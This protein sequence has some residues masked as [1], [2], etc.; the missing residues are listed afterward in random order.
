LERVQQP[1]P[2][3]ALGGEPA[4]AVDLGEHRTADRAR[5]KQS[6]CAM[7]FG[8]HPAVV[9][10]PENLAGLLA[11]RDHIK[12]LGVVHGHGLLAE[13][14]PARAQGGGG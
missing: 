6:P 3:S 13:D 8:I 5:G 9:R 12:G 11:R 10:D 4:V 14:V 7:Q 2:R 1:V